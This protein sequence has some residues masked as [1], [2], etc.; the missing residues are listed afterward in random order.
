MT[1]PALHKHEKT[2]TNQVL[3]NSKSVEGI[4]LEFISVT[5]L[6]ERLNRSEIKPFPKVWSNQTAHKPAPRDVTRATILPSLAPT[7]SG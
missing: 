7:C 6:S 4:K 2:E 3:M 1:F 5:P